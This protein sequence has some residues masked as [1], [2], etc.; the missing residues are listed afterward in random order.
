MNANV[1]ILANQK[2]GVGKTT[3]AESLGIGLVQNGKKVLLI[4]GDAQGSLS[5][6]LGY[7][8][9]DDFDVTL[10]SMMEKIIRGQ[11][12]DFQE[13]ILH[14]SEGVDL[15]PASIDLANTELSLVGL[16][17]GRERVLSKLI[18]QTRPYY[19]FVIVDCQPSLGMMTINALAAADSVIIPV[20]ADFLSTR[21]LQQLLKSIAQ[22]REYLNPRLQ[23]D[24][25][26]FTMVNSRTVFNREIQEKINA[27]YGASI[28]V[29]ESSIPYSVRAAESPAKGRSIYQHD[30]DGK[31]AAAYRGL[32]REVLE[33][34]RDRHRTARPPARQHK[35]ADVAR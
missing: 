13:G 27:A 19:D 8:G 32:T 7:T 1:K 9:R 6:S 35:R 18:E 28:P 5:A 29:F 21:G 14:H 30:P 2:G 16:P 23:V 26:L 22:T 33:Q 10:A 12:M 24:G 4:D 34:D 3:T 11:P 15:I 25:I 17:M 31:V 20:Q